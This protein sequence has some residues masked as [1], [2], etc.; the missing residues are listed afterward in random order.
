MQ[1]KYYQILFLKVLE[2]FR[3]YF[4]FPKSKNLKNFD[5][6]F[7]DIFHFQKIFLRFRYFRFRYVRFPKDK[8][9]NFQIFR[10]WKMKI[11]SENFQNFLK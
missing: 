3:K 6:G 9:E 7:W 10:F 2:N 5:F 11:F 1:K 4:H 8:I